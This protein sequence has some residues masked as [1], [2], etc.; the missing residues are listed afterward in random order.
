MYS[1]QLGFVLGVLRM[2]K[3]FFTLQAA[4]PHSKPICAYAKG[5]SREVVHTSLGQLKSFCH[6]PALVSGAGVGGHRW[7]LCSPGS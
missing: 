7:D 5:L 3:I 1:S 2:L 6:L 4:F